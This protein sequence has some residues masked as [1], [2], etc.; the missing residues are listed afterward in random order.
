M[1]LECITAK[2]LTGEGGDKEFAEKIPWNG[3]A[4]DVCSLAVGCLCGHVHT[5]TT[6]RGEFPSL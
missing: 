5:W 1:D 2:F 3:A 4:S 6:T